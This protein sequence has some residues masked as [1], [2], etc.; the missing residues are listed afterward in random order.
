MTIN[1]DICAAEDEKHRK[2]MSM[3]KRLKIFSRDMIYGAY[4]FCQSCERSGKRMK[5]R[6]HKSQ[7]FTL[8]FAYAGKISHFSADVGI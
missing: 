7:Y 5:K 1:K 4:A 6:A 3:K 2:N 8:L